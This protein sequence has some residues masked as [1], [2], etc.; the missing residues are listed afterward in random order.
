[1][2]MA[3]VVQRLEEGGAELEKALSVELQRR[4]QANQRLRELCS[5]TP[6]EPSA[7]CLHLQQETTRRLSAAECEQAICQV[8][9]PGGWRCVLRKGV[10]GV[11]SSV[12]CVRLC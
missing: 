4:T 11:S 5:R 3:V 8:R 7:L 9:S 2:E 6:A 1:Q 12:F 10:G